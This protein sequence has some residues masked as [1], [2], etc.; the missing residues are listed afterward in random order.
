M[1]SIAKEIEFR[2]RI[3]R[4]GW[5]LV[6]MIGAIN[7][8]AS[9]DLTLVSIFSLYGSDRITLVAIAIFDTLCYLGYFLIPAAVFYLMSGKKPAEPIKF[10][11][12]LSKYLPLMILSGIGISQAANIFNDC[13][14]FQTSKII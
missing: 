13:I 4:L 5:T 10:N 9:A 11:V 12:K 6:I 8:L 14:S 1:L 3:N 2:S 7:L